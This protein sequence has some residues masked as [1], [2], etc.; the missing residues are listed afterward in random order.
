LLPQVFE[1]GSSLLV[2]EV[3]DIIEAFCRAFL[4]LRRFQALCDE[5]T[6]LALEYSCKNNY[7]YGKSICCHTCTFARLLPLVEALIARIE[8]P[9]CTRKNLRDDKNSHGSRPVCLWAAPYLRQWVLRK[10][11]ALAG[12]EIYPTSTLRVCTPS[13]LATR[14]SPIS[15]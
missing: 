15:P 10:A 6:C 13:S 2:I 9:S 7:A 12:A 8:R 14:A 11:M 3:I 1:G 4:E 5:C